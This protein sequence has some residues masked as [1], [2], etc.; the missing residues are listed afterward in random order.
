MTY[1]MH[2]KYVVAILAMAGLGLL[3]PAQAAP[4]DGGVA[5]GDILE[6]GEFMMTK[7][8]SCS[9]D[10]VEDPAL[11]VVGPATL[12]MK[13]HTLECVGDPPGDTGILVLG[14]RAVV[15]NGTITSCADNGVHVCSGA[16]CINQDFGG[17]PGD[18]DHRISGLTITDSGDDGMDVDSNNNQIINN[19]VTGSPDKG[20]LIDADTQG[21]QVILNYLTDNNIGIETDVGA[22]NNILHAN[23]ATGNDLVD[24]LDDGL[25]DNDW[26]DN[27]FGTRGPPGTG[28]VN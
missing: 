12:D 18:G 7:D 26:S 4:P 25:C 9:V 19:T 20:I 8:L 28:C 24:L 1:T 10:D 15:S 16:V 5:C 17:V 14:E 6:D 13:G 23:S 11:T 2:G 27:I 22:T 21:N 3:S